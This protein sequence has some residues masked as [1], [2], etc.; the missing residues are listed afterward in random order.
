MSTLLQPVPLS[1][2]TVE[3]EHDFAAMPLYP[4]LKQA[5]LDAAVTYRVPAPGSKLSRWDHV[6]LLNL[7]FWTPTEPDD[8]IE[9][10]V[11]TADV[12]AHRAWHHL[13]A[14]ALGPGA[15][16]LEGLMLGEA[17]AS[18]FDAYMIGHLLTSRPDAAMLESQLPA[19]SD[20]MLEA[21]LTDDECSKIFATF[22]EDPHAAFK[23]LLTL[24]YEVGVALCQCDGAEA[25]AHVLDAAS[26]RPLAPLLHHYRLA[27]WVLYSRGQPPGVDGA[28]AAALATEIL[29]SD[30]PLDL[31]L[32]RWL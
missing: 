19:M 22:S 14:S 8:V 10:R 3:D 26:T 20:A 2:L 11:L 15:T 24:L 29:A 18:A 1:A 7:G 25:A 23:Q 5:L 31:L 28:P 12:I 13:A 21:G 4:R 6:L 27:T 30:D 9:G 16:T 32:T 17:I